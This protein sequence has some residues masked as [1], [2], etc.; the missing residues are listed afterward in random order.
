MI[1]NTLGHYRILEKIGQGGMGE[2]FLADD[3]SL[4][5][6]VALKFLPPGMQQDATAHRR[7]IREAQSAAALDHPY[8]CHINEICESAGRDFIVMEYVDGRS[9]KDRLERGPLPLEDALQ[10]GIEVAEALDAAHAKGII[11]RDIKPANIMLTLSGHAKVM[12]F[13]LAKQL[14]SSS[15]GPEGEEETTVLTSEGSTVGTLAYTSPEQ[16]R[17]EPADPRS[18]EGCGQHPGGTLRADPR[19]GRPN[20]AGVRSRRRERAGPGMARE[21]V[22]AQRKPPDAHRCGLGLGRPAERPPLP[23]SAAPLE[24][25]AVAGRF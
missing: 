21:S 22:R 9:L 6:R 16:L 10:I 23:E 25:A 1:G 19:A 3:T 7:F 18:D 11:H 4:H 15:G 5:R 20:R 12:D 13:G 14:I 17:G 24:P 2:V 8:I